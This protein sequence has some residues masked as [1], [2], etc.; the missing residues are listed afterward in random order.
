MLYKPKPMSGAFNLYYNNAQP[1][2]ATAATDNAD[3]ALLL[4]APITTARIPMITP[5]IMVDESSSKSSAHYPSISPASVPLFY[6]TTTTPQQ[7]HLQQHQ[8]QKQHDDAS[9]LCRPC[10]NSTNQNTTSFVPIPSHTS[11]NASTCNSSSSS[12]AVAALPSSVLSFP[13]SM[14][15]KERRKLLKYKTELC[16][17]FTKSGVCAF[18]DKCHYAH[19]E[20]QLRRNRLLDLE[21]AGLIDHRTHR[22]RPC[23]DWCATGDCPF[24]NRC[25]DIHDFKVQGSQDTTKRW[26][27]LMDK[28]EFKSQVDSHLYVEKLHHVRVH[29]VHNRTLFHSSSVDE[30]IAQVCND[31]NND[32]FDQDLL[33]P[34][35]RHRI[36]I[37]LKMR[38]MGKRTYVYKTDKLLGN[39]TCMVLQ[40]RTFLM[41][42]GNERIIDVTDG[43][44]V[45][46]SYRLNASGYQKVIVRDIAFGASGDVTVPKR[47]LFFNIPDDALI[48]VPT[49]YCFKRNRASK[50]QQAVA[51]GSPASPCS[52][53]YPQFE[54]Y[55][56]SQ[57]PFELNT[58]T[59]DEEFQIETEI[60]ENRLEEIWLLHIYTGV[61]K[62]K[63]EMMLKEQMYQTARKILIR[64]DHLKRWSWPVCADRRVLSCDTL[65]PET[66]SPYH[67]GSSNEHYVGDIWDSFVS[68]L[69]NENTVHGGKSRIVSNLS[70][71]AEA[72]SGKSTPHLLTSIDRHVNECGVWDSTRSDTCWKSLLK[73][74]EECND[75]DLIQKE[76]G[77]SCI[78][79]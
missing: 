68:A 62:F 44:V 48:D 12:A 29:E 19:G 28:A 58:L 42:P 21:L 27:P 61:D 43:R 6:Y 8:K 37:S 63:L 46:S 24:G 25:R 1:Y 34:T 17:D 70:E 16:R 39:R 77:V 31:D 23:F 22:V 74:T 69:S 53:T 76:V 57:P 30:I 55:F 33:F 10:G 11:T 26:L 32:H 20:N 49:S 54:P 3:E 36:E 7:Q 38:T 66:S 56:P 18:G 59:N 79:N 47:A 35:K 60:L 5:K 40:S 71:V 41:P 9:L 52:S 64:Q 67:V 78:A 15:M 14:S 45:E 2:S 73:E 50:Q 13:S 51:D 72:T 65:E 4:S 75:W